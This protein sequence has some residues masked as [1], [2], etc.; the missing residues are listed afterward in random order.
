M[1]RVPTTL[2]FLCIPSL[3]D[4]HYT[5]EAMIQVPQVHRTHT[6]LKVPA[7]K[8]EKGIHVQ[9]HNSFTAGFIGKLGSLY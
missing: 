4:Q 9:N 5:S 6:T 3:L 1:D 7:A 8:E 2:D